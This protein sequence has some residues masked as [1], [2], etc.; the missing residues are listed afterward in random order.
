MKQST[1]QRDKTAVSF[2]PTDQLN[3]DA[4]GTQSSE[5]DLKSGRSSKVKS[6]AKEV[7]EKK[8]WSLVQGKDWIATGPHG[9]GAL[10]G[11]DPSRLT[12][13]DRD[14]QKDRND[15]KKSP[16][17]IQMVESSDGRNLRF[18]LPGGFVASFDPMPEH[19]DKT[20]YGRDV[21]TFDEEES[22]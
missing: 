19:L 8:D 12:T 14:P 3:R 18:V 16:P 21:W 1:K 2:D 20:T 22:V 4:I 6:K 9:L 10:M 5:G 11:E 13:N 17:P 7:T 15:E